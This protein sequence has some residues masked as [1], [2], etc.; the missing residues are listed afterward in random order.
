MSED[1][2]EK[3]LEA[4]RNESVSP[5]RLQESRIRIREKLTNPGDAVCAEFRNQFQDYADGRLAENRRLLMEDHLSRC[6]RCRKELA[7]RN[8]EAQAVPMRLARTS[9]LPRWVAW[10]AAAALLAGIVYAGRH[11]LDNWFAP[12]GPRATVAS[13][14]GDLYRLPQGILKAGSAVGENE[15]IRT[16]PGSR[17]RLRLADGSILD[18]NE[19]TELSL[20]AVWSGRSIRLERGDIIVQAAK[21]R[22]GHLRVH[23]R[24]SVASVK[25]TVFAVSAGIGGT[26]VS[27]VEGSVA[28]AREGTELDVGAGEQ[29]ASNPSLMSSVSEA[30]AWSPDAETYFSILAS[31]SRIQKQAAEIP[32]P[33]LR[34]QSI[35]LERMPPNMVV[36][37]AVPNYGDTI[38]QAIALAEQQSAENPTFKEWWNS[39]RGQDLKK[40][41]ER[42]QTVAPLLGEEIVFGLCVNGPDVKETIP[43]LLAEVRSGKQSDLEAVLREMGLGAGA[44]PPSYRLTGEMLAAS[45]TP[46]RLQ[47]LLDNLGRGVSSPFAGEIAARYRDGAGWLLGIDMDSLLSLRPT[48]GASLAD[49]QQIKHIFFEQLRGR[50]IEENEVTIAFKGPRSG[51][52]S[53]LASSGSGGAAEYIS[54]DAIAAVYVS[55]REPRGLLEEIFSRFSRSEPSFQSHLAEIEAKLGMSLTADLANAFGTESAFALEGLAASGPLWVTAVLVND[56]PA[57]EDSLRRLAE[58]RN[59]EMEAKGRPGRI[60]LDQE[61][62]DGRAWTVLK[63]SSSSSSIFWTYDRGYMVAGPDRGAVVRAIATR[64]GGS[65]LVWSYAFRQ[66]LPATAGLHPPGFAW[67]NTRGAL[68]GVAALIPNPAIQRLIAERDPVLVVMNGATEQI[69]AVSRTRLSGLLMHVM[70]LEGLGRSRTGS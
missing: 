58:I 50:G 62:A 64:N 54:S 52:A 46:Q 53:L 32:S 45:D 70:L 69:R 6:P 17:A 9:R 68:Q 36:Y 55:T 31:L 61:E 21:Q 7:E 56:P 42:L 27:V 15:V 38:R 39:G 41:I 30:V 65:P 34:S 2:L 40:L 35:L 20:H 59:A 16:G 3:A 66:Q 1:R 67:L 8:Q 57:V 49:S 13:L 14:A 48:A 44:S 19:R 5:E 28:V 18:V 25:G 4:I 43:V 23:T 26:L 60:L 11:T 24:D 29:A 51:L 22:R 63:S 37:G 12:R 33:A 47:W 10:A